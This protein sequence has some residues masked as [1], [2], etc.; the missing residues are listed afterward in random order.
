MFIDMAT[1][2]ATDN[3]KEAGQATGAV[4]ILNNAYHANGRGTA[5]LTAEEAA[6]AKTRA[7]SLQFAKIYTVNEP[8]T[9]ALKAISKAGVGEVVFVNS[10]DKVVKAGIYPA[11]AYDDAA[12]SQEEKVTPMRQIVYGPAED[13]LNA[14][15]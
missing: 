13:L 11:S 4:V 1:V 6:L 3:L 9:E 5:T 8:T 2:V 10:R 12:I 15:K 7:R 14:S